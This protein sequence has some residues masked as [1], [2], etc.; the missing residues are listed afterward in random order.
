M[1]LKDSLW[2]SEAPCDS[3]RPPVFLK[4]SLC[5][6]GTPCVFQGLPV[7]TMASLDW[8]IFWDSDSPSDSITQLISVGDPSFAHDS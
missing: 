8:G 4:D 7:F 1:N 2:L 6:S 5:F 3:T